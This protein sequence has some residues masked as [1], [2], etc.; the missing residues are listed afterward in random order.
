M[1]IVP[2]FADRL[3]AF[4]FGTDQPDEFARL[5]TQWHDPEYLFEFFTEHAEDLQSGFYGPISI[6][7]AASRTR[8]EARR[9][10][11]ALEKLADSADNLDSKFVP[12]ALTEPYVLPRSKAAGDNLKTWLRVYAIK[13]EP[14]VYVVT[15]GAIKLTRRMQDRTHTQQELDK[16]TRCRDYLRELGIGDMDGL[17]E[18]M[19]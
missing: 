7:T 9:L 17:K 2:I 10:E 1:E 18:L 11:K 8:D 3:F 13:I 16:L 5:F 14:N 15:G 12:L 6:P 19:I 4:R